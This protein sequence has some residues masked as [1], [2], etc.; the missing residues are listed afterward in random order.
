[1]MKNPNKKAGN[2]GALKNKP[3]N[4]VY[5]KDGGKVKVTAGG[6]KHVIYKKTTKRGEGK[7]GNVM[8]N[9]P[10]KDKGVW[11]TI[12]L[13]KKAGAKTI[14]QGVAATKKW[15]KQ[16]PYND[17]K[18]QLTKKQAGGPITQM[19]RKNLANK[20]NK[21]SDKLIAHKNR[22]RNPI[23]E[24]QDYW[25]DDPAKV[26]AY[27]AAEK[28][29][30][31]ATKK[32]LRNA[33]KKARVTSKM[34]KIDM[35]NSFKQTGGST[36]QQKNAI[37]NKPES[38]KI[39]AP[40]KSVTD[41]INAVNNK[42]Q[43]KIDGALGVSDPSS[44]PTPNRK[45]Q[46]GGMP[47]KKTRTAV[48]SPSGD[49]KTVSKTKNTPRKYSESSKTRRTIRGVMAGAP[50]FD[51]YNPP[52]RNDAPLDVM[53]PYSMQTGGTY[54]GKNLLGRTVKK[55]YKESGAPYDSDR[56]TSSKYSKEVYRKDGS[57]ARKKEVDFANK[58]SS[59]N[60]TSKTTLLDKK[61]N[62]KKVKTG[63]AKNIGYKTGGSVKKKK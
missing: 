21:L 1:M 31:K 26:K 34:D 44:K 23:L 19:R 10:T 40:K 42:I 55:T 11:D 7:V 25:S 38:I 28:V 50:K 8:V 24:T 62:V 16:N 17:M 46:M 35:R 6:E 59:Y 33:A 29:D 27:E 36:P 49:Y 60:Q 22:A 18:K 45:M 52:V 2:W 54:T 63:S 58:K 20:Y 14:K 51:V 32:F 41:R 48:V 39:G 61:G 53:T 4:Q 30:N 3:Q 12:D 5:F 13:T 15:H 43:R 57:L 56:L 9:H 37:V 47:P